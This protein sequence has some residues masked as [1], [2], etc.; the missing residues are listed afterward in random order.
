MKN[1]IKIYLVMSLLFSSCGQEITLNC[2]EDTM[3]EDGKSFEEAREL[4][5]DGLADQGIRNSE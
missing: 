1:S 2:I 3:E 4:C 5:E